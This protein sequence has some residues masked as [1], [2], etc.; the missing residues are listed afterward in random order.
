MDREREKIQCQIIMGKGKE[1]S[2]WCCGKD[3]NLEQPNAKTCCIDE[4]ERIG[5]I[6]RANKNTHSTSSDKDLGLVPT[7]HEQ[8]WVP[9]FFT[10]STLVVCFLSLVGLAFGEG[11]L[12]NDSE[13]DTS[14]AGEGDEGLLARS[15]GENL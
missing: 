3:K 10:I 15:D 11:S 14:T 6:S 8:V 5:V 12:L 7:N 13:A 2:Y 1:K 9:A 4:C